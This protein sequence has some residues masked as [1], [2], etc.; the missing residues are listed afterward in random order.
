MPQL[1]VNGT[2]LF[3]EDVGAGRPLLFLHGWAGSGRVW[4]AQLPDF[5]ADHRVVMLDWRGCGRFDHPAHGN[6]AETILDDLGEV[7]RGLELD[8]PVV[9]G[10]SIGGTFATELALRD[11]GLISGA[12]S[13]DGPAFWPSTGMD[14]ESVVTGLRTSR[15]ATVAGWVPDWY[16]PGAPPAL[17]DWTVGQILASG[18]HVD[19]LFEWIV[20]YDPRPRLPQVRIPL[21]Y[22]HGEC[23]AQIPGAVAETCA[24]LTPGATLTYVPDAGHM[25]HLER[26]V[27]FNSALRSVLDRIP[28]LQPAGGEL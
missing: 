7:I 26:P 22:L 18:V 20:A 2:N 15:A 12:I 19:A 28:V 27:A 24:A 16:V 14:V 23:D 25:P 17:I 9:I 8:R 21:H 3:Y 13:V 6:D 10:S 1:R 5:A 4:D 11:P